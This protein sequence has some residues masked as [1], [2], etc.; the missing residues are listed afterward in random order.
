TTAPAATGTTGRPPSSAAPAMALD[1]VTFAYPGREGHPALRDL[2]FTV[3]EFSRTALVGPSGAGKS[4]VLS[5]ISRMYDADRGAVRL[6]GRDVADMPLKEVRDLIG[7]V[8]Q[9]SPVLAGP[10]RSNPVYAR[11]DATDAEIADVLERTNLTAFAESLPDGLDT[12]VGDGGIL[13]SGGQRQ[14]IAIARMLLKRPRILLLDEVTS[15]MDAENER[16]LNATLKEA[17]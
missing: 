1:G 14:R 10:L 2:S 17:A 3:P 13:V 8:E 15:Q 6:L 5:L 9:E 12:E 4:T 16:L 11:P 7:Q